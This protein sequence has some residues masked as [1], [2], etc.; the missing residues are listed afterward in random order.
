MKFALII[1]LTIEGTTLP[2]FHSISFYHT[3]PQ[4][5]A[6]KVVELRRLKA[7]RVTRAECVAM[8]VKLAEARR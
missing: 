5:N 8:P 2:W 7:Y 6:G 3:G 4:C 1:Y